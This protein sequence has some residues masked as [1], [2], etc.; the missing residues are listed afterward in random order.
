MDTKTFLLTAFT[1][2]A[3][4][5]LYFAYDCE[6]VW[7]MR[8]SVN[9]FANFHVEAKKISRDDVNLTEV[10]RRL[11]LRNRM[12][13]CARLFRGSP[14]ARATAMRIHNNG[15]YIPLPP[16]IFIYMAEDCRRYRTERGY[17]SGSGSAEERAFP[18]AFSVLL[19]KDVEQVERLLRAI[20]RPQNV[21]CLHVDRKAAVSVHEAASAIAS[22]LDNVFVVP[23][24]V[25]VVWGTMTV[26]DAERSCMSLLWAHKTTW[27]YFINLTGQEFPLKTNAELVK[28]LMA[29]NGANDIHFQTGWV[30]LLRASGS[31]TFRSCQAGQVVANLDSP[32]Y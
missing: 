31:P 17:L 6:F 20:Y 7:Q 32:S 9:N 25:W 5:L 22:C 26:L 29:Y 12:P 4:L 3:F 19:Y 10:Y 11:D 15:S 30:L 14:E 27:R 21:Y 13:I 18:L 1:G 8:N 16:E 23:D 24:P 28:I 2:W